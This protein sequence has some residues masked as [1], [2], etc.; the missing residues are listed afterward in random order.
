MKATSTNRV[1]DKHAKQLASK[2][3]PRLQRA[4]SERQWSDVAYALGLLPHKSEEITKLVGEG[5]KVVE[6]AA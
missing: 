5:C 2:L 6:A 1:Q 4:E 3:A